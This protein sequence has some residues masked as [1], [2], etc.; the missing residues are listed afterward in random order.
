MFGLWAEWRQFLEI[1]LDLKAQSVDSLFSLSPQ[2]ALGLFWLQA[3]FPVEEWD[4]L[5]N[6]QAVFSAECYEA[7]VADAR[8]AGLGVDVPAQVHS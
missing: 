8:A 1:G 6:G 4:V 2:S 3:H 5:L 7:I